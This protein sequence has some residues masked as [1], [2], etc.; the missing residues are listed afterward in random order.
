MVKE[1]VFNGLKTELEI[2]EG[3]KLDETLLKSKVEGAYQDVK[4]TRNYPA[5]YSESMI[6]DDMERYLST[7][8]KIALYDYN[9]VGAEGQT[10]YNADGTSIR[11]L[12]R[13]KLFYG[14]LPIGGVT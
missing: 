8:R 7:I 10:S 13:D 2:T 4:E 14:V 3:E 5:S 6:D 1:D 12:N 9:Q 11:Y